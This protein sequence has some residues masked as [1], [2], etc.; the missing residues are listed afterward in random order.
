MVDN[1][2][3]SQQQER[4]MA[5]TGGE[6]PRRPESESLRQERRRGKSEG[7][8]QPSPRRPDQDSPWLGGG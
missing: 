1:D 3:R 5:P 7:R 6:T 8:D 4:P 2:D